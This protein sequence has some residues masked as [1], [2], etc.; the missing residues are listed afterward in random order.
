[1]THIITHEIVKLYNV[2]CERC[3]KVCDDALGGKHYAYAEFKKGTLY[4]DIK[5]SVA[6]IP[7]LHLLE[8]F[9]SEGYKIDRVVIPKLNV[10]LESLSENTAVCE[11][12][13]ISKWK[14][15]NKKSYLIINRR[16][17][18]Y[19]EDL[20]NT[21]KDVLMQS[22]KNGVPI[23]FP[24]DVEIRGGSNA[25][26]DKQ[27][28]ALKMRSIPYAKQPGVSLGFIEET[29]AGQ[30]A[31]SRVLELP[32]A[33]LS[34]SINM[35][36]DVLHILNEEYAGRP[37]ADDVSQTS[38]VTNLFRIFK[39][40]GRKLPENRTNGSKQNKNVDGGHKIEVEK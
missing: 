8:Y 3:A 27:R 12:H 5:T 20:L 19:A 1:M 32:R 37:L 10:D 7:A 33:Q 9:I 40:R 4:V 31:I 16:D 14:R 18:I 36:T 34:E 28:A 38:E 13:D 29:V 39:D 21:Y 17:G 6:I 23:E 35:Y 25:Q 24:R 26:I 22:S 15:P 30:S 2:G 11:T